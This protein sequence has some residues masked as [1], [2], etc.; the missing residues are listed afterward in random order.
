LAASMR[1]MSMFVVV[2]T[3]TNRCSSVCSIA[4]CRYPVRT[5]PH[6]ISTNGWK[7]SAL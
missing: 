1:M 4:V 7:A 2:A 6:S 3:H 5:R